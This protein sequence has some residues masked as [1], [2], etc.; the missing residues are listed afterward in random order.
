MEIK[1]GWKLKKVIKVK[2]CLINSVLEKHLPKN[3]LI[4]FISMDIEGLEL[5][6]LKTFNFDKF[7]PRFFLIEELSFVEKDFVD[8]QKSSLYQFLHKKGYIVTAKTMRTVIFEKT[9]GA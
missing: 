1:D 3:Q 9:R 6:V 5:A 8:Y 4:D 7:S 2:T